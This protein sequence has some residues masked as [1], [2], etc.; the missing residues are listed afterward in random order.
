M[1]RACL[2]LAVTCVLFVAQQGHAGPWGADVSPAWT[3]DGLQVAINTRYRLW[4]SNEFSV[5]LRV[6]P[7]GVRDAWPIGGQLGYRYRFRGRDVRPLLGPE[8]QATRHRGG[9]WHAVF[10]T[11][12]IEVPLKYGVA[13]ENSLGIGASYLD[14]PRHAIVAPDAL[15]RAAVVYRFGAQ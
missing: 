3:S 4:Q 12:G 9:T 5:G 13:L 1:N 14:G 6:F 7:P 8:Y 2:A 11:Y 10:W 15:L